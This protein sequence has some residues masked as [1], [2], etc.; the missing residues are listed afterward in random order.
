MKPETRLT[1]KI[2]AELRKH[3]GWW[4]KVHGSA[5]QK[6]GVPDIIGCYR[7]RFVALEVKLPSSDSRLSLMQRVT[8][9]KLRQASAASYVVRSTLAASRVLDLIDAELVAQG[10]IGNEPNDDGVSDSRQ[11]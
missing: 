4:M 3:G 2:M 11:P 6:A 1:N 9:T 8:L 10:T 7:G 5:F